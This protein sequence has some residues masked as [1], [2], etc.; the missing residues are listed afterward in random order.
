MNETNKVKLKNL[1]NEERKQIA[2]YYTKKFVSDLVVSLIIE[3]DNIVVFD[4]SCGDGV[5]LKSV[6]NRLKYLGFKIETNTKIVG[7]EIYKPAYSK[8]LDYLQKNYPFLNYD[9]YLG[10]TFTVMVKKNISSIF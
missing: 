8:F 5:L 6:L 10:D 2:A 1:Q 3:K 7:I 4:P 9:I